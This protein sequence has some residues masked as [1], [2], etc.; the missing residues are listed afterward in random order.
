[1]G[2]RTLCEAIGDD[3]RANN[4]TRSLTRCST[5]HPKCPFARIVSS[6]KLSSASGR[7]GPLVP[8]F[9]SFPS[10][11]RVPLIVLLQSAP[12]GVH[13]CR[14]FLSL[15]PFSS[16]PA[17]RFHPCRRPYPSR[18]PWIYAQPRSFPNRPYLPCLSRV[19]VPDVDCFPWPTILHLMSCAELAGPPEP[20]MRA[21]STSIGALP[22]HHSVGGLS[23]VRT[24][25]HFSLRTE[26]VAPPA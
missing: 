3:R 15:R 14:G 22:T 17:S 2:K 26:V 12:R 18:F 8:R 11:S 21:D 10:K 24:G 16:F 4:E 13:P 9:S 6:F 5:G 25:R 19:A 1:M 20:H 7:P 23:P